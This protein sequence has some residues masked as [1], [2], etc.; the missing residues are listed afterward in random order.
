MVHKTLLSEL[1]SFFFMLFLYVVVN[2]FSILGPF[3]FVLYRDIFLNFEFMSVSCIC[4]KVTQQ[5]KTFLKQLTFGLQ[6]LATGR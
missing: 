2:V 4:S 3:I 6:T 1:T 5:P